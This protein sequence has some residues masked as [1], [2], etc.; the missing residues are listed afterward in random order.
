VEVEVVGRQLGRVE[1]L[2]VNLE[3][4]VEGEHSFY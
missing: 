3:A 2:V 1:L 4:V